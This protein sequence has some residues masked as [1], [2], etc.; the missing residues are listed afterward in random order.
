M[1]DERVEF[2]N[3]DDVTEKYKQELSSD[4]EEASEKFDFI[5][6]EEVI[7]TPETESEQPQE[8]QPVEEQEVQ[9]EEITEEKVEEA[10]EEEGLTFKA[11]KKE[12]IPKDLTE[13]KR[14]ASMGYHAEQ[15]LEEVNR[16]EREALQSKQTYDQALQNVKR[17]PD[18]S[19]EIP[20]TEEKI[21]PGLEKET[22]TEDDY[23]APWKEKI[24]KLIDVV[25]PLVE[26]N[27]QLENML[28]NQES[29]LYAN[30]LVNEFEKGK[31]DFE[32]EAGIK[33]PEKDELAPDGK[34]KIDKIR[35][36]ILMYY[37]NGLRVLQDNPQYFIDR[38]WPLAYTMRHAFYEWLG[39]QTSATPVSKS[40]TIEELKKN[41]K[42][43][44]DIK[45]DI[46]S[47]EAESGEKGD[48]H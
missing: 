10:P 32:E 27:K 11:D 5:K 42:L 24:N 29:N 45:E 12:I 36:A 26:K 33:F 20:A 1:P 25:N 37:N 34:P 44:N 40:I 14:Y 23:D 48:S 16:R 8:E 38:G 2:N 3:V 9:E 22:I 31:S 19:K 30:E 7:E 28:Y 18:V 46:Y 4:S 35:D 13:L 43:W 15:R 39:T 41:E 47:Q 21:L 6:E 17:Q